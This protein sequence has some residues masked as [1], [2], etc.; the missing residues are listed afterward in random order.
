[1]NPVVQSSV[2]AQYIQMLDCDVAVETERMQ[3]GLYTMQ[4]LRLFKDCIILIPIQI[5]MYLIISIAVDPVGQ[6]YLTYLEFS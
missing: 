2:G 3:W 1:M 6:K 5:F 4:G